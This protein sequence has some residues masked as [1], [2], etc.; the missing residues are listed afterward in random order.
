MQ[1]ERAISRFYEQS[2]QV[3]I[4]Q[5]VMVVCIKI[6]LCYNMIKMKQE[7]H[8]QKANQIEKSL[9]KLLPDPKGENVAAV[10]ELCYGIAQHLIAAGCDGKFGLHKDSHIGK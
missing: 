7:K 5:I 2:E 8:L 4:M 3:L 1:V 9:N 6:L 10:V